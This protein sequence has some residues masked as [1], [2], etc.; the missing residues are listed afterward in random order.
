MKNYN[1]DLANGGFIGVYGTN[2]DMINSLGPYYDPGICNCDEAEFIVQ[3]MSDMI[4]SVTSG[5]ALVQIIP[6]FEN[7]HEQQ[8][9]GSCGG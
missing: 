1:F 5:N 3:S 6:T 7:T 8:G 4:E 9:R 2:T